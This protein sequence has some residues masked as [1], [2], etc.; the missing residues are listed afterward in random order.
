MI[1]KNL[2]SSL[3]SCLIKLAEVSDDDYITIASEI[4]YYGQTFK[5]FTS[6]VDWTIKRF[7]FIAYCTQFYIR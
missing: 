2:N 7:V 4:D 1:V 3:K 5:K 6:S